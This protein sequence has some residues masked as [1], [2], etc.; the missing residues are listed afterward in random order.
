M[1]L[2]ESII[3]DYKA[4]NNYVITCFTIDTY[5]LVFD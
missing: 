4:M 3:Q 2:I 1:V 5:T